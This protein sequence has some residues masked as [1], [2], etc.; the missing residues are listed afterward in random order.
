M[1]ISVLKRGFFNSIFSICS[2]VVS[3][4]NLKTSWLFLKNLSLVKKLLPPQTPTKSQCT[5]A[6]LL[7]L[8]S[9]ATTLGPP[10]EEKTRGD[11]KK[12]FEKKLGKYFL[13]EKNPRIYGFHSEK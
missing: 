5:D 9:A 12:I 3:R 2:D 8:K 10:K 11:Q 6:T 4:F 7:Q 1:A 13:I